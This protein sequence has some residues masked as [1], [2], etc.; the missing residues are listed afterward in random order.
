MN[1]IRRQMLLT[2]RRM[3]AML[4]TA[5][6]SASRDEPVRRRDALRRGL[7]KIDSKEG[8]GAYKVTELWWDPDEEEWI[9]AEGPL[10]FEQADAIDYMGNACGGVNQVVRF[11]EHRG[12]QGRPQL[13]I[14]VSGGWDGIQKVSSF[15][16]HY[17]GTNTTATFH[18]VP[19]C[20]NALLEVGI[21]VRRC[22]GNGSS[23]DHPG[24]TAMGVTGGFMGFGWCNALATWSGGDWRNLK[25]LARQSDGALEGDGTNAITNFHI[26]CRLTAAGSLDFRVENLTGVLVSVMI[27]AAMR[28][29][30][31]EEPP[32]VM[33][34]GNC[35]CHDDP[36]WN[37]Y[38]WG[39]IP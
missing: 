38:E 15:C 6:T 17:S 25:Y 8:E 3:T 31:F 18:S 11:W 29:V 22:S 21:D 7:A 1:P 26:Q 28:I 13:F 5:E 9:R 2:Q 32:G 10:G 20:K 24:Y 23:A 35:C 16:A 36:D 27:A 12:L 37:E 39:E 30:P 4:A 14:D 19:N 34:I 33:E